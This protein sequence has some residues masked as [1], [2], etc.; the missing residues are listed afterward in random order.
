M[1]NDFFWFISMVTHPWI[2]QKLLF[3]ASHICFYNIYNN[4]KMM[5]TH[6]NPQLQHWCLLWVSWLSLYDVSETHTVMPFWKQFLVLHRESFFHLIEYC[7]TLLRDE[8]VEFT[9]LNYDFEHILNIEK[10]MFSEWRTA[11]ALTRG[12]FWCLLPLKQIKD[13]IFTPT[14]SNVFQT[15]IVPFIM[16]NEHEI[17]YK[18]L[19][20]RS[21]NAS[22]NKNLMCMP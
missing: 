14:R 11:Y 15:N 10:Y 1:K 20:N 5:E 9:E 4:G 12:L 8:C 17:F 16:I 22:S 21:C 7:R 3:I 18:L 2:W 19:Q 6:I 13:K